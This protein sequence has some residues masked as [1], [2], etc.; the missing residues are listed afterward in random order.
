MR[1]VACLVLLLL[2]GGPVTAEVGPSLENDRLSVRW[3]P[4]TGEL[5]SLTEKRTGREWLVQPGKKPLYSIV[6]A[7]PAATFSS[8]DASDTTV[9]SKDDAIVI[10]SRHDQPSLLTVTCR[11]RFEAESGQ[12]LG[13]IGV[14]AAKPCRIAEVRFPRVTLGLP[15]AE[16]ASDDRLLWP[17]CDGTVLLNPSENRADRQFRYPGTAS[18]QM[19]TAFDPTAGLL[20]TTRDSNA[21]SKTFC[22]QRKGDSIEMSV[23]H[24]LPQM[25]V[26]QWE[27]EYDV[28]LSDVQPAPGM[29]TV[30]WEAAANVYRH[31]AVAQPWCRRT[32]AERVDAGDIPK[33]I[34][35]PTLLLTFSLR[36]RLQDGSVGNRLP[37]LVEQVERWSQAVGAP[38]TCL[39][40]SWEKLDTWT[41][42][43]YLPP[44]GGEAAFRAATQALHERGHHTMVFLS[45]LHWTLQKNMQHPDRPPVQIDQQTEFDR[46]GRAWAISSADGTAVLRGAP[47]SGIGLSA[48][49]CPSTELAHEILVDTSREC[50]QLGIDLVQVD[51]IVGGG[52]SPCYHPDHQHPPGGGNWGSQ[53]LY[54][55]FS[56][57]RTEGKVSDPDFAFAIEEPGEFYLPILDTYHARDL[58]QGRW[59]R[60]GAGVLGVPLFT[61]VY[62]EYLSGYGSEGCYVS[63][64]PSRLAVYQIGMNLVCGK[65]PAAAL[66][67]RWC[68]PERLDSVQLRLLRAHLDLWRG[69]A[70]EFL[71]FGRRVATPDLNVSKMELTFTEKDGKTRRTLNVPSVLHSSWTLSDGRSGTVFACVDDERT[72]FT[73]TGEQISLEPGEAVFRAGR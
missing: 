66:W 36:G 49:I 26:N 68:D 51:Q 58:H 7:E 23:A 18:L 1:H 63:E 31:W 45:G 25:P 41:T 62:H 27:L 16:L 22:T 46:R 11:F 32:M 17:E 56:D 39:I 44:Y 65:I 8:A 13:R 42:P 69:P 19:M 9:L 59:P 70:G 47:D 40:I 38:I 2:C 54:R 3:D 55:L 52:M 21:H 72:E 73:F 29:K 64:R 57:I 4:E 28:A 35:E 33:W 6:L 61:H 48:T 20:L 14:R 10:E 5:V 67:S 15:F 50:R 34:T 43:D 37:V 71:N 30:T 60:S 53:A 12:L 24:V